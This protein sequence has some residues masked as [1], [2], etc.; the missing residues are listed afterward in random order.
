MSAKKAYQMV[1]NSK[2]YCKEH[3]KVMLQDSE[4]KRFEV[5]KYVKVLLKDCSGY[6]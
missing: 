2:R 6:S 1:H 3:L 5:K 4:Q